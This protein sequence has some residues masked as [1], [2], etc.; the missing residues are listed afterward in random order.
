MS[1][2]TRKSLRKP[3]KN[4]QTGIDGSLEREVAPE[5]VRNLIC[6][7]LD[8]VAAPEVFRSLISAPPAG[9]TEP[10]FAPLLFIPTGRPVPLK[11]HWSL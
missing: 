3:N 1:T 9:G 8:E 10:F 2:D 11:C 5:P 6:V 4:P 7:F